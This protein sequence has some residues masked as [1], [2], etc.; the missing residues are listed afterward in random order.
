[1]TYVALGL[2]THHARSMMTLPLWLVIALATSGCFLPDRYTWRPGA[3]GIV[4]DHETK[5][6]LRDARVVLDGPLSY[7]KG[8]PMVHDA[9]SDSVVTGDDGKFS[10]D[11]IDHFYMRMVIPPGDLAASRALLTVTCDRYIGTQIEVVNSRSG[12]VELIRQP[13]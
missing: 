7:A 5:A 12:P 8:D 2:Q 6:P 3:D 11:P 9:K 4:I 10:F 1:M 13:K